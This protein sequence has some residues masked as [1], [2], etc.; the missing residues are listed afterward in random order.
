MCIAAATICYFWFCV[1]VSATNL[2]WHE[3]SNEYEAQVRPSPCT[4]TKYAEAVQ[5]RIF[6]RRPAA[7]QT[8][9][10]II[11]YYLVHF[12][13]Y[14]CVTLGQC[15]CSVWGPQMHTS[16]ITKKYT[17]SGVHRTQRQTQSRP[18]RRRKSHTKRKRCAPS[19]F[20][21]NIIHFNLL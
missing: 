14:T 19:E 1:L 11:F 17:T 18:I 4:I 9:T 8:A 21:E 12:S 13:W 16:K 7:S 10:A 3:R 2:V 15:K 20:Y 6:M 5:F